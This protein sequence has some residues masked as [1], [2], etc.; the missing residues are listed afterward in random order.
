[1]DNILLGQ[2]IYD[3]DNCGIYLIVFLFL[4]IL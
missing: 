4:N 1:M 3:N 2:E